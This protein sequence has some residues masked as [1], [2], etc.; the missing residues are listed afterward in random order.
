MRNQSLA[1]VLAMTLLA[2]VAVVGGDQEPGLACITWMGLM[3]MAPAAVS[4][5]V[6]EYKLAENEAAWQRGDFHT[7]S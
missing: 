5:A 6:G 1:L 2:L 3:I 7:Q 4:V